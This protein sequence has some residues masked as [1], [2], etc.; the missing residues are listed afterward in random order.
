MQLSPPVVAPQ[1]LGKLFSVY[2]PFSVF[3]I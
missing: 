1:S 3:L 2:L